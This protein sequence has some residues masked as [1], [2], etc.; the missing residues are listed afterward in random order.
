MKIGIRQGSLGN[1]ET[2]DVFAMAAELGYDGVELEVAADYEDTLLASAEG[3]AQLKQYV[4]ETG[5]EVRS[6]CVGALWKTSPAATDPDNL[7]RARYLISQGIEACAEL[8]AKWFLLPITPS[9]DESV[10]HEQCTERWIAEVKALAPKAEAADVILCLENVGRGCG[11]SAEELKVLCDGV[12]SSHVKTYFDIGNSCNFGFD[13]MAEMDL[14]GDLI[15]IVHVKDF[16]GE[17][18][19]EGKVDVPA[20]MAKLAEMGYNDWLVL[21]TPPTAD[22]MA[23][24][25]TNLA[26]LKGV[27]G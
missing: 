18:L 15:A 13:T 19:G 7:A 26:Y 11:K 24:G 1:P 14:L 2:K 4:A 3:R 23:A 22:A 21:E 20:C 8:G 27:V 10:T 25:K 17:L 16:E 5:V 9:E 12:G 6:L